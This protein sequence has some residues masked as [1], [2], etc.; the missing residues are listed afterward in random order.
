MKIT[1]NRLTLLRILLLPVPCLLLYGGLE[2]KIT[3]LGVGSLLGLTDY[4]DG[5]LA[6]RHGV[7]R[8]GTLLDP[9][10]DKIFVSVFYLILFRIGYLPLWVVAPILWREFLVTALR[11]V[12]PGNLPVS[13]L[14]KTKTA[15]QMVGA[16]VIVLLYLFQEHTLLILA[17]A[18]FLFALGTSFS[19]LS[20]AQKLKLWLGALLFPFFSFLPSRYL[21][22]CVGSLVLLITWLS[23]LD[24]LRGVKPHLSWR[25]LNLIISEILLP[26]VVV[27]FIPQTGHFWLL[28][29]AF[30]V[31]ELVRKTLCLLEKEHVAPPSFWLFL[32]L[33]GMVLLFVPQKEAQLVFLSFATLA[34]LSQVFQKARSYYHSTKL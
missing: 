27:L 15:F 29:L 20:R 5:R 12:V 4:F 9:I 28:A 33:G 10:A 2:A 31:S 32:G 22:L 26:F 11:Q 14:A 23:A 1:A 6:R 24:Y 21:P 13:W 19:S 17:G 30:L 7:T 34:S 8:L 18:A 25:N 3:A 16:A